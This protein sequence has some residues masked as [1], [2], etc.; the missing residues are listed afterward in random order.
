MRQRLSDDPLAGLSLFAECTREE[1]AIVSRLT[2]DVT[3]AAGTVLAREG[4]IANQF[5]VLVEGRA[6]V[7]RGGETIGVLW[8][9]EVF[10]DAALAVS[11]EHHFGLVAD[12]ESRLV[13]AGV[14]QFQTLTSTIAPVTRALLANSSKRMRQLVDLAA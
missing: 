7:T 12:T 6:V 13:V 10:G 5:F 2:E 14:R 3:V 1:L 9:G 8:P 4:A 11:G